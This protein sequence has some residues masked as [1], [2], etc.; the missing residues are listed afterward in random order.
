MQIARIKN[1]QKG[2]ILILTLL[3]LS[4][5]LVVTLAAA[6]LVLAGLRMNRLTGYS[7]IAFFAAEAGLE[8]ALWEA[9]K[10][11]LDLSGGNSNDILQC[12][13]PGS[14]VLANGSSYIVSYTSFP[15]NVIF[16]SIGSFS[17]VKRSVEGTYE[18]E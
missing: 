10:N 15:P 9:R 4:S 12:S 7:S 17:G 13:V 14:C 11:N 2:V 3:I 16:K 6:D 18:V 1:D 5:I 8:R